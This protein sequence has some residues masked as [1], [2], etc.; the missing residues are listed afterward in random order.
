MELN[1]LLKIAIIFLFFTVVDICGHFIF[2]TKRNVPEWLL[3]IGVVLA[4]AGTTFL[5]VR[6]YFDDTDTNEQGIYMAY[7]YIMDG[8]SDQAVRILNDISGSSEEKEVLGA[9]CDTMNGDYING[10]FKTQELLERKGISK[11]GK[12]CLT[13]LDTYCSEKLGMTDGGTE[14]YTDYEAYLSDLEKQGAVEEATYKSGSD[15]VQEK[16][17]AGQEFFSALEEYVDERHFTRKEKRKYEKAYELDNKIHGVAVSELT[18]DDIKDLKHTYGET[19]EILRREVSFYVYQ[20][21][22]D[23]AKEK[24]SELNRQFKSPENTV[25]YT[26]VIA[27]EVYRNN[28]DKNYTEASFDMKDEEIRKLVKQAERTKEKAQK[29]IDEE[30]YEGKHADEINELLEEADESYKEACNVPIKRAANYI[31]VQIPRHGDDTGFYE[32]QLSKLYLAMDDRDTANEHLHQIIDNSAAISDQSSLKDSIDE[33]V[34]QY[35][36]ISNDAYNPELNAAVTD[37]VDKQSAQVVPV[38]EDTI[39]GSFNSYVSTTLK[40]DRISIHI[41]RID[42][43]DYPAIRAYININGTKDSKEELADQFTKEDFSVIDT[44]YEITDFTL[45]SGAESEG[46]SIGIVMDKSGS[47]EGAALENAK[48]AAAEA[49]D[50]ITAEKMMIISYDN[51][52]YLEQTLTSKSGTLKNSINNISSGGGTNISA[53]LNL[54][55]DN[56]ESANGSRAVILMSDGQD[57]GSEEDMQAAV[58]RA[59]EL[60]ISVYTV[61]F[62]ECDDAYMQAI[63]EYTGGKFVK[64]EASTELSDIY[65]YLQ[66]YIVNNYS[67]EY[68][69]TRNPEADPRF[70]TVDI[71]E[72]N[73]S[74]TKD[75]Y[76]NEE[77]RPEDP[78]QDDLI[79]KVDEN[80]L[81]ISSVTPGNAS[82]KD[83]KAGITVTVNG[84]GFADIESVFIGNTALTDIQVT[85]RTSLTGVLTG[86]LT[87]GIYDVKVRTTDGRVV[88]GSAAFKVFKAGTSESVRIGDMTITADSIGQVADDR[89]AASGNVMINGFMHCSGDMEMIVA[90]MDPELELV[91]GKTI[92]A[93]DSG[94]IQGDGKLYVSYTEMQEKSSRFADLVMNGRDY[95]VA[96]SGFY[97]TIDE[98][99][100]S[101]DQNLSNMNISIPFIMDIK[102][103]EVKLYSNRLQIDIDSIRVDKMIKS[104]IKSLKHETG[105]NKYKKTE[106]PQER[107]SL[108]EFGVSDFFKGFDISASVAVTADGLEFGGELTLSPDDKISFGIFG[109]NEMSVKLNSLDPEHEYW[110]IGGK[111]DFSTSIG[112]FGN[113]GISGFDG[114]LSSYYWIPDTVK[115]DANLR[116]G[117]RVCEIMEINKVGGELQGM[118]TL[119]IGLYDS[120]VS[121]ET[122]KILNAGIDQ[123]LYDKD[124]K[125]IGT[126]EAEADLFGCFGDENTGNQWMK[127]FRQWGEIG[128]AKGQVEINFSEPEFAVSAEMSLLGAEKAKAGAKINKDGLDISA[129]LELGISGFGCEVKGSAAANLGGNFTERYIKIG[130]NGNVDM[131]PV[132]VHAKGDC[133]LTIDWDREFSKAKVTLNYKANNGKQQEKSIWYDEDGGL[134]LWDKISTS[135]N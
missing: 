22:Y 121:E 17:T 79:R 105:A 41:S 76:I 65:L 102:A 110:K 10:Y 69:V 14:A 51:E 4:F 64:A 115:L 113:T 11:A 80:T 75:Y 68:T 99:K 32:L 103:A 89:L 127:K 30:G 104:G 125:L 37:L 95:I 118:S 130:V 112:A 82:E 91:S 67:I 100:T 124:I 20:Q 9:A 19:E 29:L 27:E 71:A 18:E 38:S 73:A 93:G 52:A 107:A 86:E 98:E 119:L 74:E 88:T 28:M 46:A 54:A 134:F 47:M 77:N 1:I 26:D 40:Y 3:T 63:A 39:N 85:D 42:T 131:A 108:K 15:D 49:V 97:A 109:I 96:E 90:D 120:L 8:N 114:Y 23:K 45:H 62:G 70:L 129:A 83:V 16:K 35:N 21:D 122:K 59:V 84:G 60:G 43:T 25:I 50:H 6:S 5:G 87:A 78:G 36:Q 33:V 132:D 72:Y 7:C 92:K 66:K 13:K 61:G 106:K 116:P 58:D 117:P 53:G 55:L 56:L 101:F 123:T 133:K 111:I 31:L 34:T 12:T 2:K 44:Q 94:T 128:N 81:G 24:A 135:S 57:G 126:V 48:Q